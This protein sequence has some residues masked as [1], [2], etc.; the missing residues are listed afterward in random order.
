MARG[1]KRV[2]DYSFVEEDNECLENGA[3]LSVPSDRLRPEGSEE[4]EVFELIATIVL[5]SALPGPFDVAILAD[6]GRWM[7]LQTSDPAMP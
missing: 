7:L 3:T 1:T 5:R 6:A 4:L 2:D